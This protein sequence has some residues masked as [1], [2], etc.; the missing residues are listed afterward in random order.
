MGEVIESVMNLVQS[1]SDVS[2]KHGV[3]CIHCNG[4]STRYAC[5]QTGEECFQ[6]SIVT[7]SSKRV[8]M[9]K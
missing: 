8:F 2:V 5:R 9:M 7:I 6:H 4:K 3:V 1:G